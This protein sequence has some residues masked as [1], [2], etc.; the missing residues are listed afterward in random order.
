MSRFKLFA[1]V[2]LIILAFGFALVGDA[3][4]GE[5]VKVVRRN[6][7]HFTTFQTVKVGDVEGHN[8]YLFEAKAIVFN[9]KWGVGLVT[10][11]GTT[12]D[13]N[14]E[15]KGGGYD[16]YTYPDGSTITEK[17]EGKGG[18]SGGNGT[19]T[20]IKGTGKFEGIQGRG[21]WK[22]YPVGPGQ[23]YSDGEGE[24]TLP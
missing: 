8:L 15:W 13:I 6:A 23:F 21:T 11:T 3:L 9:E 24:Y 2:A 12:D 4:A 17:W 16:Q 14:G 7:N 22:S 1:F 10:V 18:A 19:L 20:A 5:K